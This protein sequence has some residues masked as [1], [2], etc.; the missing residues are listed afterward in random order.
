MMED[1]KEDRHSDDVSS[2]NS[3]LKGKQVGVAAAEATMHWWSSYCY[4]H[5]CR[6]LDFLC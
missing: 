4:H 1:T 2:L 6:F 3:D 5:C